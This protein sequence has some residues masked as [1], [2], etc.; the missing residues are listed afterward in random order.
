MRQRSEG[1]RDRKRDR[2]HIRV[3][4]SYL[5]A[6]GA[7]WLKEVG[8]LAAGLLVELEEAV[9]LDLRLEH[10]LHVRVGFLYALQCTAQTRVI[11]VVW[12]RVQEQVFQ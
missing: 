11:G 12:F 10:L 8:G 4:R 1:D 5:S 7:P 9:A 2:E 3:R 6:P